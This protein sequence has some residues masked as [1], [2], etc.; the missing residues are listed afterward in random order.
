MRAFSDVDTIAAIAKKEMFCDRSD[1]METGQSPAIVVIATIVATAK[2]PE[3][4]VS[5]SKILLEGL[6][7]P[8]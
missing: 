6:S 5:D 8:M 7:N 2:I 3:E 1:H 4:T